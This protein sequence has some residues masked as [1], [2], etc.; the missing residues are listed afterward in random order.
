M[1][2]CVLAILSVAIEGL[3]IALDGSLRSSPST[4]QLAR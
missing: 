4:V 2:C 3:I 1:R